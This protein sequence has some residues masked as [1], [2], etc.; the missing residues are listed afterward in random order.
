MNRLKELRQEKGLTQQ[1]LADE[2]GVT[3][4]TYIYWEKGDRQIKPEKA[5]QLADYFGVSV[6]YLLGYSED[7]VMT[8]SSGEE[9][10]K[11]RRRLLDNFFIND[12]AK[13]TDIEKLKI[14]L[15][16]AI[17]F[18]ENI[19]TTLTNGSENS[20]TETIEN[21]LKILKNLLT[22]V[23]EVKENDQ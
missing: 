15:S 19:L 11:E 14:D 3:K 21:T 23:S 6:G 20:Y 16:V 8:F 5:Q 10:E 1:A 22:L 9:F 7:S 4:R 12:L 13:R 17:N 2:M 18:L